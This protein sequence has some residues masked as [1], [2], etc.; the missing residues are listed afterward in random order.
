MAERKWRGF[1][2]R[3]QEG[4]NQGWRYAGRRRQTILPGLAAVLFVASV[5]LLLSWQAL[6]PGGA[7][8]LVVGDVVTEDVRAPYSLTYASA[9]LTEQAREQARLAVGSIYDPPDPSVSRQQSALLQQ[10][11]LYIDDVRLDP[12]ATPEQKAAD[13]GFITALTLTES[14][15][16]TLALMD[17]PT[18]QLVALET[19]TV[20]ERVMRD[21]VREQDLPQVIATLPTQVSVRFTPE[22]S[23][24]ISGLVEDLLR[25][26]SLI[27]ITATDA[28]RELAVAAVEPINRSFERGQ[29]IVR[30]GERIDELDSETLGQFGLL[31]VPNLQTQALLR[32]AA[33]ALLITFLIALYL[34][35]VQP[36]LIRDLQRLWVL[37]AILLLTLLTVRLVT[38]TGQIVFVP[39]A[40]IG[41]VYLSLTTPMTA[42]F[43]SFIAGLLSALMVENSLEVAMY[44]A[45]GSAIGALYMRS[46]DRITRYFYS[47]VV[48]G[49]SNAVV[50]VIFRSN[51]ALV[52]QA[53]E[54]GALLLAAL[55]MGLVSA[56]AA[57]AIVYL[58]T[59]LLNLPTSLRLIELSQPNHPLLQRLLREA[60]GTYQH[61]LQ[62]ANLSEQAAN[63]VG[64]NSEL[65]RVAALYHDVGK[66][67][68]PIF[69]IE[70]QAEQVNPH[71]ALDDPYRSASIIVS[72]V[73]DGDRL[74]RQHRIPARLRDFIW[75]H[76]GTTLV[77]YFYNRALEQAGDPNS[78]DV[79]AFTYP[80]P[81]PQTRETAI[82]MLA[83]SSESTVRARKPSS[84][85][86]IAEIVREIID[87]RM[88]ETQLDECDLTLQDVR[89]IH[90]VFVE[91]LQGVFHPRINYPGPSGQ[92][93][94]VPAEI[95]DGPAIAAGEPP[96]PLAAEEDTPLADVPV[97]KRHKPAGADAPSGSGSRAETVVSD[98]RGADE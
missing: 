80:G 47:G 87:A 86:E 53:G 9:L 36:D 32:G 89:A 48:I 11:L 75:Q 91:V 34:R 44:V 63:A 82:V 21:A 76:H 17:E 69:F 72:H 94:H 33:S 67:M 23:A 62:V 95:A 40:L 58:L 22:Q 60:P 3:A 77:S 19:Q 20:L 54:L 12:Y 28:A 43:A 64:A 16:L 78:V 46:T 31:D 52:G 96:M 35:R 55:V 5:T 50:L 39:A 90:R 42:V 70:N 30:A 6:I 37:E 57:L 71:D 25:P 29:V 85:G 74:A 79:T 61:S 51:L 88:D 92:T 27:N 45:V 2:Q 59:V 10:I 14:V 68:N 7:G 8:S 26:N 56:I 98:Q 18:W 13:L 84:R 1:G 81:R 73:P 93:T 83:D 49:L 15:R 97:L 66:M 38:L 24:A 4:W 65:V 41:M